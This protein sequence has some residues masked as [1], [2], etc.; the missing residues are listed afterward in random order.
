M[1]QSAFVLL[2]GGIDSTTCLGLAVRDFGRENVHTYSVDY[3]QRHLKEIDAAEKIAKYISVSH[4]VL[5]LGP[6]PQSNLTNPNAEIPKVSYAELPSGI[7]PSYHYFRNAQLLSL[8]TAYAVASLAKEG[9]LGTLYC[10][11][12]AED[13]QNWAYADCTPEFAGAMANAIFIGTYQKI[14]LKAPLLEMFKNEIVQLG[15]RLGVPY[16]LSWSCY[17]GGDLHCGVCPTCRARKAGFKKA[18]VKDPTIYADRDF[19]D[20]VPF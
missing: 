8:A 9:E 18:G 7:S 12:H 2:S 17:S 1:K 4:E 5:K 14:R 3:G 13:A 20:T 16:H 11:I 19:N 6:Q 15:T 10:G